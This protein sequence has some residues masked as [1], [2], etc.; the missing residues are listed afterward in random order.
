M[1]VAGRHTA[2][3]LFLGMT[4]CSAAAVAALALTRGRAGVEA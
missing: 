4:V 1:G 3:P 2:V